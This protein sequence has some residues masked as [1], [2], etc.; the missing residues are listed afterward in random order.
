MLDVFVNL[1]EFVVGCDVETRSFQKQGLDDLRMG[2]GL[3]RIIALNPGQVFLES[4]V[5]I[6]QLLVIQDK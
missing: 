1:H 4:S 2:I 6:P 3:Y 5:I